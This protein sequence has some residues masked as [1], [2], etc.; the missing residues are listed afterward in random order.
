MAKKGGATGILWKALI[1][2]VFVI[3]LANFNWGGKPLYKVI[4]PGLDR[5][6]EK[7]VDK[8]G[9]ATKDGLEKA[10]DTVVD[11]AQEV[12]EQ[13]TG[14]TKKSEFSKEDREK[15]DQIIKDNAQKK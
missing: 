6:V 8:V 4:F 7:T 15:L 2:V 12:K 5:G 11:A 13:V 9:D 10:K 14:E 3:L 1:F